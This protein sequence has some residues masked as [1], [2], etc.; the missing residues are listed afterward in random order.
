MKLTIKFSEKY[1][2]MT[3]LVTEKQAKNLISF[4]NQLGSIK[5]VEKKKGSGRIT[6]S[7]KEPT[8]KQLKELLHAIRTNKQYQKKELQEIVSMSKNGFATWLKRHAE[9]EAERYRN[10]PQYR[11]QNKGLMIET[12][13]GLPQIMIPYESL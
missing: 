10:T 2:M 7:Y 6:G 9:I 4:L 13:D 11:K 3:S 8:A 12:V 1:G 5:A